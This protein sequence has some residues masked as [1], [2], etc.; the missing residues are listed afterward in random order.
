MSP[1]V[2][3]NTVLD[4]IVARK[5]KE[6]EALKAAG[7]IDFKPDLR[8][9]GFRE[10]LVDS[11]RQGRPIIA[12]VKR[13]S[14]SAGVI[15]KDFNPGSIAAAYSSS[16]ARCIS[17][18]T[19]ETFFQGSL[20]HLAAVRKV[21]DLPLLRKDFIIDKVQ[22]VETGGW[23]ADCML[24]IVRILGDDLLK[25]LYESALSQGLEVLLEVHDHK[26]LER[27]LA[28]DPRPL[29][30][31]VNNRDLADFTVSVN[32]TLSLLPHVPPDTAVISESGLSGA[33]VLDEL[34]D[35]GVSGFLVGTALMREEDEGRALRDLVY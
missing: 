30:L 34:L 26:D 16:G 12:E 10:A 21:C 25:S 33:A 24:L 23:G 32:R 15:R 28:L 19:D 2:E 11:S 20:D 31:G 1:V 3:T 8:K 22:V 18:L 35:S 29:L 7:K 9:R 27:A 17:V 14:P 5:Q 4:K 6:V 13:A